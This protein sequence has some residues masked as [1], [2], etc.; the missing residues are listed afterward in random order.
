MMQAPL[1]LQYRFTAGTSSLSFLH[2][3]KRGR[4]IGRRCPGCE[5][6]YIPCRGSCARCGVATCDNIELT[7]EGVIDKFTVVHIPIPNNP[8]KPPFVVAHIRLNGADNAFHHLI[9]EVDNDKV[10]LGMKVKAVWRPE[11]E[12]DYGLDNIRYF[13]PLGGEHD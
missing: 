5:S 9:G 13:K 6:V 7:D 8:I 2:A 3:I 1:Y 4:L 12:W 10:K 11:S